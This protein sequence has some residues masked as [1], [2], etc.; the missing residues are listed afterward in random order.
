[1][2]RLDE[3][4]VSMVD[5]LSSIKFGKRKKPAAKVVECS[6]HFAGL[7][8]RARKEQTANAEDSTL[9]RSAN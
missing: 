6:T 1:M 7:N 2:K 5:F 4:K 9:V 3:D 8:P